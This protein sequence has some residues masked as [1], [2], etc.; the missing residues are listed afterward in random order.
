MSIEKT[1]IILI[2]SRQ[3]LN[4]ISEAEQQI[5]LLINNIP[6]EQ[7]KNTKL[8]GINID[9]TLTWDVQVA[10]IK[11]IVVYKLFLLK[12][13]R[14]LLPMDTRIL[15]FNYYIKP[16]L[17]YCCSIWGNSSKENLNIIVKLQK[18]AAR[19]ILDADF[20]TPSIVLFDKLKWISFSDI[21]KYHQVSLVY[22]C[23]H[24][25]SPEYL[26]DM[27]SIRPDSQRYNLRSSDTG[28]LVVP[29]KHNR[30]LSFK[31]PKLWNSLDS[32]TRKSISLSVFQS[33]VIQFFSS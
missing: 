27:F 33:K 26:H 13:I 6:I 3:K 11:K 20:F 23:I 30:S 15:F 8:L 2:G 5:K 14:H 17:E 22:K 4:R 31:G 10:H 19:L 32:E 7:I 12:R 1:K 18:R 25:I 28:R 16:Y 9:S 24:Q 29:K 21:V